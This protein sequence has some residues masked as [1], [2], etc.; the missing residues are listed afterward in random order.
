[1]F[2]SVLRL[3]PAGCFT[4][5]AKKGRFVV[6]SVLSGIE[7]CHSAW[8]ARFDSLSQ[9]PETPGHEKR[10]MERF[11]HDRLTAGLMTLGV[12]HFGKLLA[13]EINQGRRVR[14]IIDEIV[15]TKDCSTLVIS[16]RA[17]RFRDQCDSHRAHIA[18]NEAAQK[19]GLSFDAAEFNQ[20]VAAAC[21]RNEAACRELGRIAELW[22]PHLPG[23]SGRPISAETCIHAM[24]LAFLQSEGI[25]PAY[26]YS[27]IDGGDFVDPEATRLALNKP[28]SSPLHANQVRKARFN[29]IRL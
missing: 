27:E 14:A 12:H 13:D 29:R 21:E 1:L 22:V 11:G 7:R 10:F 28:A 5:G 4:H 24:F 15:K 25:C 6:M 3:E 17:K 19:A 8:G 23:K 26:T 2:L 16:R 20:L 9:E 18:I